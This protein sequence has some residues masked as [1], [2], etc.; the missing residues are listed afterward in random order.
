MVFSWNW[1]MFNNCSE[2]G[3]VSNTCSDTIF[4]DPAGGSQYI[5]LSGSEPLL[6]W[7]GHSSLL[8]HEIFQCLRMVSD[9]MLPIFILYRNVIEFTMCRM[10]HSFFFNPPF[11]VLELFPLPLWWN[12]FHCTNVDDFWCYLLMSPTY[13]IIYVITSGDGDSPNFKI[14]QTLRNYWLL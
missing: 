10:F 7:F 1:R 9:C 4:V 11:S 14:S 5:T 8:N 13:Y 12:V 3:W 2:C 6:F